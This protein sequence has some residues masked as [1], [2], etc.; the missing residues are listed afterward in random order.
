MIKKHSKYQG[1]RTGSSQIDTGIGLHAVLRPRNCT[2]PLLIS[3]GHFVRSPGA[4]KQSLP[5]SSHEPGA[6]Q[7]K[8]DAPELKKRTCPNFLFLARS[9]F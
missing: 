3:E 4:E 6:L 2:L 5:K 9:I 8:L 1:Q 7:K